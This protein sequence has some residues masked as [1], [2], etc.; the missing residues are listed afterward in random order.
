MIE[1]TERRKRILAIVVREYIATAAPVGSVA[2][3][4]KHDLG[5]RP[6]TIRNEM[7]ALEEGGYLTQPHTSAGRVPTIKGYRYFVEELMQ[8]G[9]LQSREQRMI[10]R[11]FDGVSWEPETWMRLSALALA[12]IARTAALITAPQSPRN[13]F[14]HMELVRLHD[15]VVLLV[16]V[17]ADGTVEQARLSLPDVWSQEKLSALA[18]ELNERLAGMDR[19]AIAQATLPELPVVQQVMKAVL[20]LMADVS[21]QHS[22][23]LIHAGIEHVLSQPEFAGTER[24]T[25]V[26][27]VFQKRE[28]LGPILADVARSHQGVRIIIAGEDRWEMISNYGLVLADYGA[29]NTRGT[30]GV[31]GPIRMPYERAVSV[32]KYMS[33]L[34][35][36]FLREL[37][38]VA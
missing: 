7:A 35:S 5:I 9:S 1:L 12:Q 22:E 33:D 32:V 13:Q 36:G 15:D 18:D 37:H 17:L 24:A 20:D 10:R 2:L 31:L 29:D 11:Q 4:S 38:G 8:A 26:V 27:Q 14:K 30:L 6:A 23:G 3:A 28:L 21:R 16:L 19:E 34:M 25:E